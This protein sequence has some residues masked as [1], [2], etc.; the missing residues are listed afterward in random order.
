MFGTLAEAYFAQD[1]EYLL[2]ALSLGDA[3]VF[4][5]EVYVFLD[6]KL[7]NEIEALEHETNASLTIACTV[8]L[9]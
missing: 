6:C 7:V 1:V 2:F 5:L 3:E 8:F 4:Q 9:L